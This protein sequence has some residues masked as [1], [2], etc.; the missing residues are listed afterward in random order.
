MKKGWKAVLTGMSC[1]G[2][3]ATAGVAVHDTIKHTDEKILNPKTYI[4]IHWKDYIPTA[5]VAATT[6]GSIITEHVLTA[7]DTKA[8][9]AVALGTAGL[10]AEYKTAIKNEFGKEGYEQ[11]VRHVSEQKAKNVPIYTNNFLSY[12]SEVSEDG[13]VLFY[14]EFSDTWFR[15]SLLNVKNAMYHFNRN[16]QLAGGVA[17]VDEYYE[18]LGIVPN[19]KWPDRLYGYGNNILGDGIFWIDFD[20]CEGKTGDGETFYTIYFTYEPGEYDLDEDTYVNDI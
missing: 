4:Q 12:Q 15:S 17:C 8:L 6:L 18:F 5:I 7:K 13:N 9:S 20:I 19:M 3:I 2:V 11:V 16:F 10:L 1:L 14:D